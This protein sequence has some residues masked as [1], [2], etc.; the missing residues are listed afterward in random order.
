MVLTKT[1]VYSSFSGLYT[2]NSYISISFSVS[3]V[4]EEVIPSSCLTD[5]ERKKRLHGSETLHVR[6]KTSESLTLTYQSREASGKQHIWFVNLYLQL[7][8]SLVQM[9]NI[10]DRYLGHTPSRVNIYVVSHFRIFAF[11]TTSLRKGTLTEYRCLEQ[12]AEFHYHIES[13]GLGKGKGSK[14]NAVVGQQDDFWVR[15]IGETSSSSED[16]TN[17]L[18]SGFLKMVFYWPS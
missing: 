11:F 7:T 5:R 6:Q 16:E 14:K 2:C 1:Y 9:K 18:G 17:K 13:S 8:Q 15:W 4:E 12:Q 10:L 3:D